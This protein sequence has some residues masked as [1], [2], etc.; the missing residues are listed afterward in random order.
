MFYLSFVIEVHQFCK[1]DRILKW[2]TFIWCL[3][4]LRDEI[5]GYHAA[6]ESNK[7]IWYN[8]AD[9]QLVYSTASEGGGEFR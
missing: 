2:E 1:C 9:V 5:K 8:S 7:D 3:K 6:L 4:F